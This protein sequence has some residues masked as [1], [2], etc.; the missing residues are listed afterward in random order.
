MFFFQTMFQQV[1]NGI[2]GSST[3]STVQTIA[4]G[5]LLLSALFGMY[6]AWARGGDVRAAA[7]AGGRYLLMGLVLSQYSTVFLSVNNA[8]NGVAQ[9][10]S[11]NDV[12]TN[13]RTQ[14]GAYLSNITGGGWSAWY[15][16]I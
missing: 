12:L 11:P 4:E 13:W 15:N 10:I 2:T 14:F 7:L 5:I 1:Y 6:E 3:L 8:F 16:L 9:M